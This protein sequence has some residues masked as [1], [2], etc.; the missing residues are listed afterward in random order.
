MVEK[1]S[2]HTEMKDNLRKVKKGEVRE[3]S[4]KSLVAC[5]ALR[6][7]YRLSSIKL[8]AKLCDLTLSGQKALSELLIENSC[9]STLQWQWTIPLG[10]ADIIFSFPDERSIPERWLYRWTFQFRGSI[11]NYE[12]AHSRY[13]RLVLQSCIVNNCTCNCCGI[14]YFFIF[15]FRFMRTRW[16]TITCA[17]RNSR[18]FRRI[19][20]VS[21]IQPPI[22]HRT[23]PLSETTVLLFRDFCLV[24]Q[25]A[26]EIRVNN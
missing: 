19:I 20:D 16:K 25:L 17:S 14:F 2:S 5:H 7:R 10:A 22:F 12:I 18:E 11:A 26:Y 3:S 23:W 13:D 24:W 9:V 15:L 8:R 4:L 1:V 21:V 6:E